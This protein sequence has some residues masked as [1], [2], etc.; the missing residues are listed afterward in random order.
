M[1]KLYRVVGNHRVLENDPG[2]EFTASLS[3]EQEK[4]LVESGALKVV[5]KK[6]PV[7]RRWEGTS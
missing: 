2:T 6:K 3:G 7:K 1:K 5:E 4:H